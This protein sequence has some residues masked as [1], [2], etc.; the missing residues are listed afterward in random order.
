V[1]VVGAA[2]RGSRLFQG[3]PD[4]SKTAEDVYDLLVK[5]QEWTQQEFAKVEAQIAAYYAL[6]NDMGGDDVIMR[7]VEEH[8]A[9]YAT[10]PIL[11]DTVD[12]LADVVIGEKIPDPIRKGQFLIN[13]TGIPMRDPKT[14]LAHKARSLRWQNQ[15]WKFVGQLAA[16]LTGVAFIVM[17]FGGA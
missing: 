7:M 13:G 1:G 14:G 5:H 4:L 17:A 11:V 3:Q 8:Q 15:F 16:I 10:L 9:M 6:R 12:V 2:H